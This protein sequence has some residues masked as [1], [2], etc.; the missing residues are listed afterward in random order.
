M[1]PGT[2]TKTSKIHVTG[3]TPP[4]LATPCWRWMG[5]HDPNGYARMK[6]DGRCVYVRREMLKCS[7][8]ELDENVKVISL[9]RDCGCVN[10]DHHLT[11]TACEARVFA[12]WGYLGAGDLWH[13]KRLV[14]SGQ[15]T[16]S[17]IAYAW[18]VSEPI[19]VNGI[20]RCA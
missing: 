11:G 2:A 17:G 19:I 6:V 5:A 9:C 3:D 10:P 14:A 18:Q 8:V 13:A 16:T 1:K 4:G 12:R 7:G 15:M 20:A